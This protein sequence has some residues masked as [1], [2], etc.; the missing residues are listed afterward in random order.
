MADSGDV[1][2]RQ[3]EDARPIYDTSVEPIM[4]TSSER[5]SAGNGP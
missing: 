2:S 3:E 4:A 5:E 1:N